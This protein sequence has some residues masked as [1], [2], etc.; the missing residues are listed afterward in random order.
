MIALTRSCSLAGLVALELLALPG[1]RETQRAQY[2]D[3][4]QA[5]ASGAVQRGWI[6]AFVPRSATDIAEVHDLDLNTQ[7]LRFRAA[8]GDLRARMAALAPMSLE[9]ARGF[10]VRTPTL[11]GAWPPELRA[12][13]LTA[14]PRASVRF[15]YVPRDSVTHCLAVDSA[16]WTAFAWNCAKR[17]I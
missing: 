2:A 14:T 13:P 11:K 12:G 10:D 17:V 15:F 4:H 5:E 6:P 8:E 1:C 7:R 9:Q 3:Y 16:S